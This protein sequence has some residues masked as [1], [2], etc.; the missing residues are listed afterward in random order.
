MITTSTFIVGHTDLGVPELLFISFMIPL[1]FIANRLLSFARSIA[2]S[3]GEF[4]KVR[5][6]FEDEIFRRM[7]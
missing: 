3:F 1:I 6:E 5:E 2:R 4:K 7:L